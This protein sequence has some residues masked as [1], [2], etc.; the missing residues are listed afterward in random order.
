M[1]KIAFNTPLRNNKYFT[2][3]KN[4]L[5]SKESLHGPGKNIFKIK[6]ELKNKFG[7]KNL[8]LTNSCT[9]A[10][11]MAALALNL[12]KDDEVLMPSYTFVT[13]GSSFARTG[14]KIK[15]IDI[16]NENLMPT[17]SEIKKKTNKNTKA[18][19][20][21][22]YQGFSVDYL[23]KL[24]AFCKKKKIFLIEDA[25]QALGSYFK[26]KPLGSF[27]DFGCF[28]FHHTKNLHAGIGG[29]LSVNN[30]KFKKKIS[31]IFDKGTDRSLVITNKRKY[32]SWVEIGSCFLLPELNASFLQP[33]IKDM[34][35]ISKYRSKIYFR[36]LK[37]FKNWL[38]DEFLVC[39]NYKYTYNFHA[40]VIILKKNERV[41]FLKYLS[42]FNIHAF[43]GYVP[44]HKSP[45]GKKYIKN[46]FKLINTD[47]LEKKIIR[48]PLHTELT[49][50]DIDFVCKKI[51]LFF[52]K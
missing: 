33:Q 52:K 46:N 31:F 14:C 43:I 9:A 27:G 26:N 50:D 2:N 39:N 25:A 48:L 12:N 13:T 8:Y 11:E 4:F 19:V 30:S 1:K 22:H 45:A 7:F 23:D 41:N 5:N 32:Y 40:L 21:V 24:Q 3:V 18:I 15:Y 29:L 10:I 20:I 16:S 17:F 38:T 37:N 6:K 36:Y 44:L 28:S 51:K 49:I 47:R 35:K 34:G 42:K